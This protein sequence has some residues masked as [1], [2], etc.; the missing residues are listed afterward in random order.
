MGSCPF[1]TGDCL[2]PSGTWGEHIPSGNF[3][4]W[5]EFFARWESF[6]DVVRLSVQEL[7]AES[8]AGAACR[9]QAA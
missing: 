1:I 2:P 9:T 5:P 4:G 7:G 6:A 8:A 3:V